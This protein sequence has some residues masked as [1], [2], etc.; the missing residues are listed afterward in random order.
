RV[1][2]A[3]RSAGAI[4]RREPA[5]RVVVHRD[6]ESAL[7][8]LG[9]LAGG[10]LMA[11]ERSEL[12]VEVVRLLVAGELESE[13]LRSQGH[14]SRSRTLDS[15]RGELRRRKQLGMRMLLRHSCLNSLRG[16]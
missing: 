9:H 3:A 15:P 14:D 1:G 12:L 7:E 4:R 13:L 10:D 2:A 8:H 6:L 16:E 11:H 5:L